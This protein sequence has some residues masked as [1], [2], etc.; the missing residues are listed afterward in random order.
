MAQLS[1]YWTTGGSTGHQQ[2]SYSQ[3]LTA[4]ATEIT[5]GCGKFEGVAKSYKNDLAGTVTGANTVSI[6]TG[7]GIVDG[8]WYYNDS[9]LAVNIPS[10]V[11][12]GNTRIDRI[13]LRCVWSTFQVT[14]YRIAGTNAATPSAPAL[15]QTHGGTYDIPLYQALVN[16]AG[17][18]TLT[19]ERLFAVQPDTIVLQ[20]KV[21]SDADKIAVG[22]SALVWTIPEQLNGAVLKKADIACTTAGTANQTVV[23]IKVAGVNAL[24]TTAKI[25]A[26]EYSSY[27]GVRGVTNNP[28][29]TTGTKLAVDVTAISTNSRGLEAILVFTL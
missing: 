25:D 23:Q 22:N 5:A 29:V 3:A 11:G 10:A 9:A 16:T 14:I 19:D 2:I 18:V 17:T 12:T 4:S 28:V 15:T 27:T 7:G 20:L 6:N 8:K 26:N 13:V 1:G 21:F 24:T